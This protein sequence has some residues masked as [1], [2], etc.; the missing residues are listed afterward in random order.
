M[1]FADYKD[2]KDCVRKNQDKSDPEAFCAWLERKVKGQSSLVLKYLSE[3]P[4]WL[5]GLYRIEVLAEKAFGMNLLTEEKA[6][7]ALDGKDIWK[8]VHDAVVIDDHRWIH[9]WA[10][11]IEKKR[12]VFLT[13]A[14]LRKLHDLVVD[15]MQR[16]GMDAG[17]NHK[18]PLPFGALELG[19]SISYY[20]GQRKPLM[21]DE[22]FV[23]LIGSSLSGKKDPEDLDILIRASKDPGYDKVIRDSLPEKLGKVDLIWDPVGPNGPY[24]PAFE[25]WLKPVESA[26]PMEPKYTIYPMSPI[27]PAHATKEIDRKS[28]YTLFE[29]SYYLE[30]ISGLR[31]MIHRRENHLMAFDSELEELDIPEKVA[32]DLLSVEDPKTFILDGFLNEEKGEP[33]YNLIDMPWWRE[34]E[35]I[36]QN[37][38]VRKYFLSKLP[39]LTHVKRNK[40][41][42][43]K[44]REDTVSFLEEEEGPYLLIPGA[45][46]YPIEGNGD[47]LL[48]A[49]DLEPWK[50]AESSDDE[51][52]SLINGNEWESKSANER[53]R[54]MTKRKKIEALYPFAQ[55]KTTKKGYSA[56]EVFGLK[57]VDDLAKDIFKVPNKQAVEV[58]IDGFRAQIHKDGDRVK[59]FT[60]SGHE[61]TEQLPSIVKDV[62]GLPAESLV[63]DAEI[64]P[65]NEDF[66]NLGRAAAAPAF[67][68][69]AKGPVDDDLWIAHVFDL[70]FLD[71]EDLHNLKYEERRKRLRGIELPTKDHPD[72][73]SDF[74]LHLWEN[75]VYW[76]TSAEG[77]INLAKKVSEAPGSEGAMFK[78]ADSKYRL[79]GNTPLWSKMKRSFEIDAM[80]VGMKKE[81]KTY[82][83]IGAI[84]PITGIKTEDTAPLESARGKKFVK[85]KGKIYSILGK[86]FNT[87]MEADIGDII[88]VTMKETRK[89]DDKVYHWF[90]PK[91]LE[92][93]EDKTKPDPL[94]TAE[95]IAESAKGQQEVKKA[96]F[97]SNAR[98]AEESPIACCRAP[99][100]VIENE[101]EW[102]YL[103]NDETLVENLQEIGVD[104]IYASAMERDIAES[105]I[106][107]NIDFQLTTKSTITDFSENTLYLETGWPPDR[108]E[109]NGSRFKSFYNSIWSH[110]VSHMKL[111]CGSGVPLGAKAIKLQKNAY[112]TYPDESKIWRYVVQLHVRG[113]SVHGDFRAEI[114]DKQLIGWTWDAGKSLI[115]PMLRR[116]DDSK[117]KEA[118]ISKS[119]IDELPIADVSKKLRSTKEG[120]SLMNQL[121]E[122][123][124]DLSIKQLTVLMNE[125]WD[126]EVKPVMENPNA[127][128]LTQRK[129][130]EPHSWLKYEGE[131]PA[132]AVGATAELEGQFIIMDEGTIEYGAQKPWYH[133]YFLDGKRLK[134]K[135]VVR[136]LPAKE[137]WELKQSF[138]WL[139]FMTK[140]GDMPY[141]ISSRGVNQD[142]M[143]PKGISAL[144]KKVR[145]QIPDDRKYWKAK[146]AKEIRDQLVK[147][148]KKKDVTLKLARG[149]QFAVK[150]VW[151]KGPEVRRGMPIVRYWVLL[152]DGKKVLDAWDFGRDSDPLESDGLLAIRRDT[153]EME[154]L[155]DTAGEISADHPASQTK[156]L[157]NQFDTSDSGSASIISDQNDMLRLRFEGDVLKGIY[158]FL[159]R[160]PGGNSWVFQKAEL[161]EPKK[162]MLLQAA[163][164]ETGICSTTGVMQLSAQDFK[165][166]KV[167][168]LL[169]IDGPAIKPG[170]VIPMDGK[171]A[172]FTKEGIKKLWPTMYRQPIVVLHG[173]LKGDVIGFVDKIHYDE[174][175]GWGVVDQGVIWHPLGMKLILEGKL[176]AFSIE[177]IPETIWD[178]EHQHDVVIGGQC[179]GLAVVPKGACVTCNY[180]EA[181][182]GEIVVKPGE[183][184]KFG[185]TLEDY[186]THQYWA[187]GLSTQRIS[188]E[189]G[190]PRS[191]VEYYMKQMGTPR[192]SY[193][194]ARHLRM[195]NEANILKFGGRV[196]IT[197]L[198]TSAYTEIPQDDCPQCKEALE[199]GKSKRNLTATMFNVGT[200]HLLVNAPSGISGML[201]LK[202]VK[203]KYVLIEHMHEDVLGGL[204]ELRLLNPIAFATE[205]VWDWLRKHYKALSQQKG[206]F[207]EIYSFPRYVIKSGQGFKLE[208]SY[209]IYPVQVKHAKEGGP[210]ALGF[211]IK[212]GDK[213]IWH[214]S[215]VLEIPN[216]KEILEDVDIYIG[217]GA[218]LTRGVPGGEA[219]YGHASIEEQIKW[220]KDI[221]KIYF[222]QIGHIKKTHEDLQKEVSKM[223]PNA[224]IMFDGLEIDVGGN[225]AGAYFPE[226]VAKDILE[227]KRTMIVRKKPYSEYARQVIL[228]VGDKVHAL[229][230]EGFPEGPLPAEQVKSM[231][232]HGMTDAEWEKE[233]G[234]AEKVWIY[235]PRVLKRFTPPKE[236]FEA[237]PAGP[238]IHDV[239]MI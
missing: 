193:L 68:K 189:E 161:P 5:Y 200:E 110:P 137:D 235:K 190:I 227:G 155:I 138:A 66:T 24:I 76:A 8:D 119:E 130:P 47:W 73:K 125:L 85:Y 79:S 154:K 226:E 82:N 32:D 237:E 92:V 139:S 114:N 127:K 63:F 27:L 210:Q 166:K 194:E 173:E 216:H 80:V 98:F 207:D 37:A 105:L 204:H 81:G 109:V 90:H 162:S 163:S 159:K 13:K 152:H 203:P 220:A 19:D 15:E 118:G 177:V 3:R 186:I 231:D 169:F 140:P 18:S 93:R 176:P 123:T 213:T 54:L 84:G 60:E 202:Q 86:T 198:G 49:P 184:Y 96:G 225:K 219:D 143:P 132:G 205:E 74:K 217:D 111:S 87:N 181:V 113:L 4:E 185:M 36:K 175:T 197:A 239:K 211:K 178:A 100:I 196:S 142:W 212:I 77:M 42:Y 171:P 214:C 62:R 1:P 31:A 156:S 29:D 224:E 129:A 128:I 48:F 187:N 61:I 16:R 179:V 229:Y 149:L 135:L 238:Y 43:F 59:I 40:A 64:T 236:Y 2:F 121:S 102:V 108:V 158:V 199:G 182:M 41:K 20:L 104:Q 174:K 222:T 172:R 12:N 51:I 206:D 133:E 188:E 146:N 192:R 112:L 221:E 22:A 131:V 180:N 147:E 55:L 28:A 44:T 34:S 26:M 14:Q 144:P 70:L 153:K 53:F 9:V 233:V 38:E 57:S 234:S 69:G 35:H 89:I 151:H 56:R 201:G 148:I 10:N 218:A 17:I 150:R 126:E 103:K 183:I 215:D 99:W 115:K 6:K 124:Q 78:Q 46:F 107:N 167:G 116:V 157:K 45:S 101:D 134:G 91:V 88:R 52:K 83:Y 230:I 25:L 232:G 165:I 106:E 160:D 208:D 21:L 65:Y 58:K 94:E 11:S 75:N 145:D 7:Q 136:Q 170:E 72:S 50:L 95:T 168:N 120:R 33:V 223:A 164:C 30:P 67:A 117:L 97:L 228:L 209:E 71:G 191:T 122:K 39:S 23:N 141:V 195:V